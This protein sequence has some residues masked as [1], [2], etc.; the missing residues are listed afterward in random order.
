[1]KKIILVICLILNFSVCKSQKFSV[2][3][4]SKANFSSILLDS[5]RQIGVGVT[6]QPLIPGLNEI[7]LAPQFRAFSLQEKSEASVGFSGGLRVLYQISNHSSV[8]MG[9]ESNLYHFSQSYLRDSYSNLTGTIYGTTNFFY[10]NQSI[11]YATNYF[12][13]DNF[14]TSE[15]KMNTRLW[16]LNIPMLYHHHIWDRKI[17]FFGGI[18]FGFLLNAKRT[19]DSYL[20]ILDGTNRELEKILNVED[21]QKEVFYKFLPA[22]NGGFQMKIY[23]NLSLEASYQYYLKNTFK[24]FENPL[25]IVDSNKYK[26]KLYS[27]NF[28]LNYKIW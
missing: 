23:K 27:L 10:V 2:E 7:N 11:I 17:H 6:P 5:K 4:Y 9:L 20:V 12:L 28:G 26:S 14:D 22:L 16:Y 1:M 19:Y 25:P 13:P 18:S 21:S 15:D 24:S 8:S 3:M